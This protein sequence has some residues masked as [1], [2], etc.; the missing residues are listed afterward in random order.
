VSRS[1]K[2][3]P[4]SPAPVGRRD[5]VAGMRYGVL[6]L[7]S[8]SF[9]LLVTEAS[10][11]GSLTHV[12]RDRVI[13]NLGMALAE[14]QGRIPPDAAE[15][16]LAV[17]RR[18]R[19]IAERAGTTEI[20]PIATSALRDAINRPELG[21]ALEEAAGAP[22]RF[23]D[24]VE[25]GRTTFTGVRAGVAPVLED[26][27]TLAFDLGGGSLEVVVGDRHGV[28]WA[29]SFPLGA[30]RLTAELAVD[31]PMPR[32]QAKRVR[33]L[34]N[35]LLEPSTDRVAEL[36]PV[37]CVAAGGTAG[38]M[39]RL[40]AA[41]RWNPLPSSLN[42]FAFSIERL[43]ELSKL[44]C[45]ASLPERLQ[46]PG[47]DSRRA[48]VLP[49]GSIVLLTAAKLLGAAEIMHSEWG[50]REGVVL[51]ELGLELPS[52]P[53]EL[54]AASI[55]RLCRLWGLD[56]SH[57]KRVGDLAL[58]LFDEMR[59]LHRLGPHE[60]ELLSYAAAVHDIGVRISPDKQHKHG[61][62]L[63]EH[64]GLR[65]F[66]PD[67][68]AIIASL[69]R[70]HRGSGPKS[71]YPPFAALGSR[72]RSACTVLVGI[73]RIA[74]ALGRAGEH[75]VFSV[76]TDRRPSRLRVEISGGQGL[77]GAVAE[78]EER[79]AVLARAL[80]LEISVVAAPAHVRT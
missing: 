57:T 51:G 42:Q 28:R 19:D 23:L 35:E 40:I 25:E 69:V 73:M 20:F 65:G 56:E 54:R 50:L 33:A 71:S 8:T 14:A 41:E 18:F 6:D 45:A 24:G 39:A 21:R 43:E 4:A 9:Q 75:D 36:A 58:Q 61:A 47:I 68:I 2:I 67:E 12:L 72:D 66:S 16:S 48:D 13:L 64:A 62:Y 44:L 46:M 55:D 22:I 3:G 70:F 17:V 52:G 5:T 1:G 77:E 34:V 49:V 78:A 60:R 79:S 15:R 31:D 7:G 80:D 30:G 37:R 63:V 10:I 11:D 59:D 74:H 53:D 26:G 76:D 38:A 32:P 29:E 27:S